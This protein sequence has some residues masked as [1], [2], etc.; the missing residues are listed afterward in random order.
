MK[1]REVDPD[2]PIGKLTEVPDFLPPPSELAKAK[3][4][5]VTMG[6]DAETIEFFKK[7][8]KKKSGKYQ[9]MMREVLKRYV[10]HYKKAA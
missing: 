4:V 9:R 1:K 6:L 3:T 5:I 10:N 7:A 2:M 8:A